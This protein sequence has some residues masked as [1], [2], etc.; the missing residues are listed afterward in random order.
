MVTSL[1]KNGDENLGAIIVFGDITDLVELKIKYATEMEDLLNSVVQTLIT[2]VEEKSRYNASH[3]RR[4]VQIAEDFL[5]WMD[6]NY[7]P[8]KMDPDK[9]REFIMSI[10]LHDV[11]KLAVPLSVMDKGT[12]LEG[13]IT[14][15]DDRLTKIKLLQKIDMLEGILTEEEYKNRLGYLDRLRDFVHR[16]NDN[17]IRSEEDEELIKY[18]EGQTY[19]NED[20][21]IVKLFSDK[22]IECLGIR[23]GTLTD[24]EREVMQSHVVIT[25]KMLEQI[26][27]P[28]NYKNV[29]EWASEHHELINGKGYPN[30]LKGD[31]I[32]WEV[33]LLTIIDI[34]ESLTASDRPYKASMD[35]EKA[36]DI[37]GRMADEGALDKEILWLFIKSRVWENV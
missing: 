34:F 21:E 6:A 11:G 33:R 8:Q 13:S 16:V 1:L 27:F 10:W 37:L 3:T 29:T 35:N 2:A 4:M 9:R 7:I 20:G 5:D 32:C 12:R 22:E 36:L 31:E 17:G 19:K 25:R 30:Q 28:D 14:S 26:K 15:I 24:K 18:I 23:R